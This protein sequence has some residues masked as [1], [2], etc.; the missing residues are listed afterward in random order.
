L[1]RTIA[2]SA[3]AAWEKRGNSIWAQCERCST[4]FPASPALLR[5]DAVEACCPKCHLEFKLSGAATR[6]GE[7]R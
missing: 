2:D 4:W 5:D 1:S 7:T 3:G 6:Q